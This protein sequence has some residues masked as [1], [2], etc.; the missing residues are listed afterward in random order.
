MSRN[1]DAGSLWSDMHAREVYSITLSAKY[2]AKDALRLIQDNVVQDWK[3]KYHEI[4]QSISGRLLY[5]I[6]DSSSLV[7][8]Y[9][10]DMAN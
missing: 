6:H 3:V 10:H 1:W 9:L 8:Y 5:E 2:S 7:E 4:A